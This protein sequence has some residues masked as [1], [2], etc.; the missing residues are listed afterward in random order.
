MGKP[1]ARLLPLLGLAATACGLAT[2]GD[3][4]TFESEC[5]IATIEMTEDGFASEY[6]LA[7]G[8]GITVL[9]GTRR[10]EFRRVGSAGPVVVLEI[11]PSRDGASDDFVVDLSPLCADDR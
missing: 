3:D 7:S 2:L 9:D 8:P 10:L 5:Q 6:D 4:V 11:D 1:E